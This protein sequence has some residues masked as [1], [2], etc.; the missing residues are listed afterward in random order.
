MVRKKRRKKNEGSRGFSLALF[1]ALS[2]FRSFCFSL[3]LFR[4]LSLFR[5]FCFSLSLFH[6]HITC[7]LDFHFFGGGEQERG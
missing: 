6:S 7:S 5:S 1:R 4:A 3:A 2:L